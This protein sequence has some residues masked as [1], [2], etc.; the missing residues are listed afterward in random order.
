MRNEARREGHVLDGVGNGS[1][2]K[3]GALVSILAHENLG[4]DLLEYSG[5]TLPGS[6]LW[7]DLV[8]EGQG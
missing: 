7:W 5:C 2:V 8:S 3:R 1:T 4:F 6:H